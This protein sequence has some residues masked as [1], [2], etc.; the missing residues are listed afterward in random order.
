[1]RKNNQLPE[2]EAS[3]VLTPLGGMANRGH[4]SLQRS[5]SMQ[6]PTKLIYFLY[7][8]YGNVI[9]TARMMSEIHLY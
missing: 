6:N 7:M 9:G 5:L 3:F 8:S 4:I 2:V 1:M